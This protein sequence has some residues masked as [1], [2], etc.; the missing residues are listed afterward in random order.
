VDNL[1]GLTCGDASVND[2]LSV[3]CPGDP[4]YRDAGPPAWPCM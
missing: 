1:G 4:R 2:P 3:A